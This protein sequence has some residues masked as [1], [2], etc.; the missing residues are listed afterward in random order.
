[1]KTFLSVLEELGWPKVYLVSPKQFEMIE[2]EKLYKKD[3]DGSSYVGISSDNNPI[4]TLHHGLRG[5]ALKN[6]I[7]HEIL[8][9]VTPY[10]QHWWIEC[11]AEKLAGGG[12]KGYYSQ[13]YGHDVSELPSR[14]KCLKSVQ[15]SVKRFNERNK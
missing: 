5:K 11:M 12:G 7:I 2:G 4:I 13:K 10:R 6:T 15:L 8:H 1:M 9:K 14:E 3:P